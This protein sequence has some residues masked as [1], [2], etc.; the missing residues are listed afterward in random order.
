MQFSL[1]FI[2]D[3]AIYCG[4]CN[5]LLTMQF[6]ESNLIQCPLVQI[7][8]HNMLYVNPRDT[9]TIHN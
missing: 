4:Q 9:I 7:P 3:N 1:N 5:L 8:C 2:E 6:M